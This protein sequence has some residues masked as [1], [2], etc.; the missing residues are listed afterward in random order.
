MVF[1][2]SSKRQ[3]IRW[4][5]LSVRGYVD[6]LGAASSIMHM[7]V[8]I[9]TKNTYRYKYELEK[10][11]GIDKTIFRGLV[12]WL[13]GLKITCHVSLMTPSSMVNP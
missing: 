8:C 1:K 13:R 11:F 10:I 9:Y 5:W 6:M 4:I 12:F 3:G 7:C 2:H